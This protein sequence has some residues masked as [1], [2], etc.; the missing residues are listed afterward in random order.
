VSWGGAAATVA[1]MEIIEAA[2][3]RWYFKRAPWKKL[4]FNDKADTACKE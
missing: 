4:R 3:A 1:H 2:T